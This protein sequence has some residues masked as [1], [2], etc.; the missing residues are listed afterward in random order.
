MHSKPENDLSEIV[1]ELE[2][3]HTNHATTP[4]LLAFSADLKAIFFSFLENFKQT[5]K[6]FVLYLRH[7][8]YR[9]SNVKKR[10]LNAFAE[11][12]HTLLIYLNEL[13]GFQLS[14]SGSFAF[15]AGILLATDK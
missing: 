7:S 9:Y 2:L 13:A 5:N 3:A 10:A 6:D 15:H 14:L 8:V 1:S 4:W 12:E 11:H